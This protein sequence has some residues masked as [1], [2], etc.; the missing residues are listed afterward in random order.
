MLVYRQATLEDADKILEL[1]LHWNPNRI[2]V[3]RYMV[4]QLGKFP[5]IVAIDDD[6]FVGVISF[7][8]MPDTWGDGLI[9]KKLAWFIHPDYRGNEIGNALLSYAENICIELKCNKFFCSTHGGPPN[10]DYS[11][12][13]TDYVKKL[14]VKELK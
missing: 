2:L 3:E 4:S 1:G 6:K 11:V 12:F 13:E 8:I 10:K 14:E 7:L 5:C 9:G